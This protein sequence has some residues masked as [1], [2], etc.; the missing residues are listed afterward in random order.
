MDTVNECFG[1]YCYF[2]ITFWIDNKDNKY[3]YVY[4]ILEYQMQ[5]FVIAERRNR[6]LAGG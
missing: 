2:S 5:Y 4:I 1:G 6:Q 3:T